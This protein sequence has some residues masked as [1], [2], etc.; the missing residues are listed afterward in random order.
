MLF[1]MKSAFDW[2]LPKTWNSFWP[3][4][5]GS[6]AKVAKPCIRP[7]C[8]QC[9]SGTKHP[10][11]I[12]SFTEKGKRRC[13]YVPEALVP[14]LTDALENGRQ[15]EALLYAQGPLMLKEFR[16]MR[17]KPEKQPKKQRKTPP[18]NSNS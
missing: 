15:L 6:L 18:R 4:L 2:P 5:K 17:D 1:F 8:P 10:A 7:G 11:Y 9:A 13:M 14:V 3:A 16:R 12:F